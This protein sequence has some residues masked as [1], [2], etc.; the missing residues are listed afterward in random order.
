MHLKHAHSHW[1]L[2]IIAIPICMC[3]TELPL[4]LEFLAILL[5]VLQDLTPEEGCY[6]LIWCQSVLTHLTHGKIPKKR[7]ESFFHSHFSFFVCHSIPPQPCKMIMIRFPFML[8]VSI[9]VTVS[10]HTPHTLS[11]HEQQATQYR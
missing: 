2:E 6:D 7:E 9:H 5:Y 8:N 4:C 11:S 1:R 10:L 3:T